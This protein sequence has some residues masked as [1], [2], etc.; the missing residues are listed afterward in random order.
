VQ[1]VELKELIFIAEM[2][3]ESFK[4]GLKSFQKK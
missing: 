3:M 2:A 1:A 4:E